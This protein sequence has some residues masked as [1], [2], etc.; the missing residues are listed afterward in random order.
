MGTGN[1]LPDQNEQH[2]RL[3]SIFHYVVGGLLGLFACMPIIH[4][5]IGIVFIVSPG[6]MGD[7]GGPP[8]ELF[9]WIFVIIGGLFVLGGWSVAVCVILAGRFLASRTHH[10]FCLVVAGVECLFM[11]FGTVLGILTLI[12]L[13]KAEV[14]AMFGEGSHAH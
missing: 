9:G 6:S 5:V 1:T 10:T 12:V 3:L 14:K 2:L 8:P 11:P 4:M 13:S 7:A